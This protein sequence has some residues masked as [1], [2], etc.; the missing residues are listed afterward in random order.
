[1]ILK[2]LF[3]PAVVVAL[4]TAGWLSYAN[5]Q[6]TQASKG[7][8]FKSLLH[9]EKNVQMTIQMAYKAS[10]S[11]TTYDSVNKKADGGH[12]TGVVVDAE[13]HILSA[14]HAVKPSGWDAGLFSKAPQRELFEVTFPDGRKCIAKGLGAIATTD[15]AMLKIIDEGSWPYASMG[16]TSSLKED[17]PCI[18]I[19][20]PGALD[21]KNPTV[22]FGYIAEMKTSQG[23]MRTTC[24]ME[25]GD[26]GGPVFDI[27]GR[28]IG[29]HSRVDR[30]LDD[31]YEVPIDVYRKY[32][33]AL[34]K[35]V[36][37]ETLPIED[38]LAS[39]PDRAKLKPMPEI[40]NAG[41][42]LKK[43]ASLKLGQ[44]AMLIKSRGKDAELSILSTLVDLEGMVSGAVLKNKS[45]LISKSS[46]IGANP[47]VEVEPGKSIAAKVMV[48]DE[49]N[50][51]AL[52]QIDSLIVGGVKLK[53]APTDPVNYA[54][55]GRF[56]I[57]VQANSSAIM[58][59]IGNGFLNIPKFPNP[60]I[61]GFSTIL[62][63]GSV[64]IDK[65]HPGGPSALSGLQVGDKLID[66]NG[67]L[68]ARA[69]DL[70]ELIK[71]C[72]P[73]DTVIVKFAKGT[74]TFSKRVVLGSGKPAPLDHVAYRFVDGQ[75]ERNDGFDQVLVHD[76]RLKPSECGGPLFDLSGRFY[77]LNIARLSRT[78]SLAIPVNLV[79]E[80]IKKKWW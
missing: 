18:S 1:M 33:S 22:R 70:D 6:E 78:C 14:A 47:R 5:A 46:M 77:G 80:F 71:Q 20:Y 45:F 75:S 23:Y 44:M 72:K 61:I 51:L 7:F 57:S 21:V 56:L 12:F 11:I 8:D 25:P 54:E 10:V 2:K 48:R 64:I 24:L 41:L 37:Y 62:R 32:W 67:K 28:V 39:D 4:H 31:N 34:N 26:S 36:H 52:L 27:L 29:L 49:D 76:G 15:A 16:W 74:R 30:N 13:G 9:L 65:V 69:E 66:L 50:D 73:Y 17:M 19:A 79:R 68:M 59:V 58:S 43:D 55:V 42:E 63:E 53:L 40:R 60:A 3:K 35:N 38:K